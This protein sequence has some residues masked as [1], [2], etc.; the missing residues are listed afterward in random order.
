[1]IT[2]L[3]HKIGGSTVLPYWPDWLSDEPPHSLQTTLRHRPDLEP[4]VQFTWMH[5]TWHT[6]PLMDLL[7]QPCPWH[8]CHQTPNWTQ[9]PKLTPSQAG[10]DRW[11]S[12]PLISYTR[13]SRTPPT[14]LFS[15]PLPPH[16]TP[17]LTNVSPL[18]QTIN[19]WSLRWRF[20]RP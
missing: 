5:Q 17:P 11:P 15:P 20:S 13:H 6:T 19:N 1:M 9:S 8:C 3:Y 14:T 2:L 16:G 18:P 4:T 10:H 12:L 7:S